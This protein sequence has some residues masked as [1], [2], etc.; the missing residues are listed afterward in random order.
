[1]STKK[2]SIIS[3][4]IFNCFVSD[5][6][7]NVQLY[8]PIDEE[9]NKS[10]YIKD[11]ILSKFE[12]YKKIF[13]SYGFFLYRLPNEDNNG[14][15]IASSFRNKVFQSIE[16]IKDKLISLEKE[17]LSTFNLKLKSLHVENFK[18]LDGETLL[19]D[20]N[21][22]VG[23][24]NSGKT[25]LLL[26]IYL[27][28]K[29]VKKLATYY[30]EN[31]G[32]INKQ[33]ELYVEQIFFQP[34]AKIDKNTTIK[35]LF[36]KG[37][38]LKPIKFKGLFSIENIDEISIEINIGFKNNNFYIKLNSI[39]YKNEV[40]SQENLFNILKNINFIFLSSTN[41]S[42]Q[43]EL[44]LY[45][46][47]NAL[48]LF[49]QKFISFQWN[50]ILR[51]LIAFYKDELKSSLDN[52]NY[53]K[54]LDI[55][56]I[57]IE[58]NGYAKFHIDIKHKLKEDFIRNLVKKHVKKL[59]S[60]EDLSYTFKKIY[61]ELNINIYDIDREEIKNI[62]I[63]GNRNQD[64]NSLIDYILYTVPFAVSEIEDIGQGYKEI[65]FLMAVFLLLR[66][67]KGNSFLIVDEPAMFLHPKYKPYFANFLKKVAEDFNIQLFF[68]TH[69]AKLIPDHLYNVNVIMV[70]K[71][72][73]SKFEPVYSLGD[74]FKFLSSLGYMEFITR[75]AEKIRTYKKILFVEGFSDFDYLK[76]MERFGITL[77][78]LELKEFAII[79]LSSVQNL[80]KLGEILYGLIWFISSEIGG[81]NKDISNFIDNLD[82]KVLI[83]GDF[84]NAQYFREYIKQD[85]AS[86]LRNSGF[87][88]SFNKDN[89]LVLNAYSIENVFL[90]SKIIESFCKKYGK[91]FEEFMEYIKDTKKE[92][93]TERKIKENL[94]DNLKKRLNQKFDK[95]FCENL[96]DVTNS[97]LKEN[98][99]ITDVRSNIEREPLKYLPG[100]KILEKLY[101]FS[102]NGNEKIGIKIEQKDKWFKITLFD[103]LK[104]NPQ[105]VDDLKLSIIRALN[106]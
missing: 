8:L 97:L 78:D 75:N 28:L 37:S 30:L 67:M 93:I 92:Q 96:V 23:E 25:S 90:T 64:I 29:G 82:I 40:I 55:S 35:S 39:S 26:A 60:K 89:I 88:R 13:N 42:F 103:L 105:L 24:N 99:I 12:N 10:N 7:K 56:D 52:D 91:S 16:E 4:N 34:I 101:E 17:I 19:E 43:D 46:L 62:K 41:V 44:S 61:E 22:I 14:Y 57:T 69:D 95:H 21:I 32:D 15:N 20:F 83:D 80:Q 11:R 53:L 84:L 49:F 74:L 27:Y 47:R 94:S 100:K 36:Y 68:S 59:D 72:E 6:L 106:Q 33:K 51:S 73:K 66:D 45:T 104:N 65:L 58:E 98:D 18:T 31:D 79:P 87:I 76:L 50:D 81:S 38:H 9:T 2:P 3:L 85:L 63:I 102:F 48:E 70:E 54:F 71:R 1:M 5:D 86:K 77:G